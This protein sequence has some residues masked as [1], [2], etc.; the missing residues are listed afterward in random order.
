M[1]SA[2]QR[3]ADALFARAVVGLLV[4]WQQANRDWDL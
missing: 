2:W 3:L 1:T 4:G